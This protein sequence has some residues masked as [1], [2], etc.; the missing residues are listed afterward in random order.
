MMQR[1]FTWIFAAA[2]LFGGGSWIYAQTPTGTNT[3]QGSGGG[4]SSGGLSVQD[5]AAWTAATSNFTPTG[6]EYNP[7][8]AALTSGQQGTVAVNSSRAMYMD[9]QAANSNLLTALNSAAQVFS[10]SASPTSAITRPG[11]TTTYTVNTAWCHLT[12]SCVT[13]FTFTG[14]CRVNGGQVLVPGIDLWLSDKQTTPLQGILW[15]F[16]VVPGTI[17]QDNATFT[18]AGADFANLTGAMQGF[19]FTM[20]S[21]QVSG[22]NAGVSITGTSYP[23]QC[24]ANSTTLYAMVQVVNAYVPTSAEILN[25]TLHTVGVN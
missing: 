15:V 13:T 2:L 10:F 21:P 12:S 3:T 20:V 17:I 6:G 7:S 11:N 8:A 23:M 1:I 22:N 14:A 5:S 19:P 9:V 25:V 18:I 4:S 16:N 24:A